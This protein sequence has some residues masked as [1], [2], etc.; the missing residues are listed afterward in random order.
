MNLPEN[1][2]QLIIEKEIKSQRYFQEALSDF[3]YDAASG[4]AIRHLAATGH[5]AAQIMQMLDYPVSM[6]KIEQTLTRFLKESGIL[7]ESLPVLMENNNHIYVPAAGEHHIYSHL[8][9]Y[10]D[11]NGEENSYIS[12]PFGVR[13]TFSTVSKLLTS[14]TTREQEYIHGIIWEP[15]LMYHRL[16]RRMLEIGVQLAAS[17]DLFYF[18]FVNTAEIIHFQF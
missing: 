16:D 18:C 12:C 11:K 17:S 4:R 8:L 2:N 1:N 5:T 14:L 15:R 13:D 9:P 3:T 7:C 10:I 6:A